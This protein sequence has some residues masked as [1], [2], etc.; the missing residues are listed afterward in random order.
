MFRNFEIGPF[1]IPKYRI[2]ETV[3]QNKIIFALKLYPQGATTNS[4]KGVKNFE[5]IFSILASMEENDIPLLIHGE[6]TDENVDIF[7]KEKSFIDK[8]LIKLIASFP[9]L[10]IVLE[11]ITTSDAFLKL[12]ILNSFFFA[13]I[14]CQGL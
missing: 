12:P 14:G 3:I 6:D 4:E 9:K 2:P 8:Y 7:D 10:R 5:S 13:L 1:S 11:H